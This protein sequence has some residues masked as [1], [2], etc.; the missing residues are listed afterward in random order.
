[1]LFSR[2]TLNFLLSV[3]LFFLAAVRPL[4]ATAVVSSTASPPMVIIDAGHGG[5]DSGAVGKGDVLEKDLNLSIALLLEG[6]FAAAGI[7]VL[8]T[9]RTDTLVLNEGEDVAGERKKNDL[10]NR[11]AIANR[12]PDATFISIHMNAYPV[13]KYRGFQAYYRRDSQES[14]ALAN[15]I[16]ERVRQTLD[17]VY[18]RVPNYR[19]EELYLLANARGRAVLVEC[20]FLSNEEEKNKLLEKDYQKKLSFC[21]FYAIME[22]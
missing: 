18:T 21:I 15:R 5:R 1:M 11:V 17:P 8:L 4:A 10:Y 9:R 6:C 14:A 7:P 20:G 16:T 3:S 2:R 12:Y 13:A 22:E 19:G